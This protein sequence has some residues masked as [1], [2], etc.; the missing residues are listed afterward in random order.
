MAPLFCYF[1]STNKFNYSFTHLSI[2]S[3]LGFPEE[4]LYPPLVHAGNSKEQNECQ[5]CLPSPAFRK[6]HHFLLWDS[7]KLR[8]QT[9]FA[10]MMH[11]G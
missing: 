11:N 5:H 2:L 9:F 3:I 6:C 8:Q 7:N 1:R 4:N 10:F